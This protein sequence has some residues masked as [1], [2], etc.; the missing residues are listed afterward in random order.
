[1]SYSARLLEIVALGTL[2]R[3][4][5]GFHETDMLLRLRTLG[6]MEVTFFLLKVVQ[7]VDVV[8]VGIIINSEALLPSPKEVQYSQMSLL[9]RE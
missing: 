7:G 6:A 8:P 9:D 5:F 3:L 2:Q 1:M 4:A